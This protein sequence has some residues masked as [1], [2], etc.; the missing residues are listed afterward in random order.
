MKIELNTIYNENCEETMKRMKGKSIDIVLTSPPYNMTSRKGGY[1]DS[2]RYDVYDDWMTVDEYCKKTVSWFK[3][4]D[5]IVKNNGVVIYN[6]SYSIENPNLPYELVYEITKK[7][8]WTLADTIVWKKASGLP[9]PANERRLSRIW[10]FVWIFVRKDEIETFE[11]HKGVSSVSA[12]TNQT[13][14]NI[15]YNFVEADNNDA[16]TPSLNQATYSSDLC[17][18]L[19]EIYGG[20]NNIVYDP[21]MGTGTTAVA[22]SRSDRNLKY[23]GSELSAA[24][25]EYARERIKNLEPISMSLF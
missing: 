8:K 9:F 16:A 25:C 5:R 6:F 17:S 3:S 21:F 18:K 24:Q 13:Y 4:F 23:I 11:C 22:C 19:L 2:G 15:F 20:E 10:E 7:T 1:A 12:K 14:Y